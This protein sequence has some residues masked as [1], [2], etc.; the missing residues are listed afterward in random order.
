[1]KAALISSIRHIRKH[2]FFFVFTIFFIFYLC[3]A[4]FIRGYFVD[5]KIG[6]EIILNLIIISIIIY[7]IIVALIIL[8]RIQGL[9]SKGKKRMVFGVKISFYVILAVLLFKYF[10]TVYRFLLL[11]PESVSYFLENFLNN[12][13]NKRSKGAI[14]PA[15]F[16]V[17][18]LVFSLLFFVIVVL[19]LEIKLAPVNFW[20]SNLSIPSMNANPQKKLSL[21]FLYKTLP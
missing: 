20:F 13:Y 6:K 15:Y 7:L 19:R 10:G 11:F 1:M 8:N 2:F 18:M 9:I 5:S 21:G 4:F 17:I 3:L 12:L 14:N 16:S